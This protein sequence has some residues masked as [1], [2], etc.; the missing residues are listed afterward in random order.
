MTPTLIPFVAS[1]LVAASLMLSTGAAA[2]DSQDSPPPPI[3]Q[4]FEAGKYQDIFTRAGTARGIAQP[5]RRV[6]RGS[7]PPQGP[8][9]RRR[10]TGP[11]ATAGAWRK[12]PWALIARS[13]A[14]RDRPEY[15]RSALRRTSRPLPCR[16][17]RLPARTALYQ[18]GL[19]HSQRQD[20]AAAADAF[21]KAAAL[22]PAFA[23]AHFYAGMAYSAVKR[24][25][26]VAVHFEAFLRLA[27]AAPERGAVESVMRTIRGK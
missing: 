14:S 13:R 23:Y 5:R 12:D 25:D 26:R 9:R 22:D 27:P 24:L 16:R 3:K 2:D 8:E 19:V 18:L 20:M 6:R 21:E 17:P 1:S 11:C 7:G 15:G 4:L 10:Q